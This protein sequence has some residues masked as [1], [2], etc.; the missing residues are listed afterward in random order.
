M[1]TFLPVPNFTQTAELLD[2]RRLGKQRVEAKQILNALS[3]GSGGWINH[4]AT[5]MWRGYQDALGLYMNV[6][7]AEWIERGYKNT[8]E[9]V[10]LPDYIELPPWLGDER[11]HSSHRAAL[12]AKDSEWYGK[13]G[14]VEYPEINYYW[15]VE[16]RR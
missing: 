10:P 16:V 11:V 8:M 14:W 4:P 3:R 5:C 12:L 9:P 7:I 2:Y 6:M 15:P 13:Y 1:Q